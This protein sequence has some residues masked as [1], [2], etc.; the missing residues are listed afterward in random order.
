MDHF[1]SSNFLL[2]PSLCS[3]PLLPLTQLR[4]TRPPPPYHRAV[5]LPLAFF[6]LAAGSAPTITLYRYRFERCRAKPTRV[7]RLYQQPPYH[8]PSGFDVV[9]PGPPGLGSPPTLR[10]ASLPPSAGSPRPPTSSTFFFFF[11][12]P[13]RRRDQ[14][15]HT[16]PHLLIA[17][18]RR[19]HRRHHIA[20]PSPPRRPLSNFNSHSLSPPPPIDFPLLL[21]KVAA[22]ANQPGP[23]TI[24]RVLAEPG[25]EKLIWAKPVWREII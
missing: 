18:A 25:G 24:V 1:T 4:P 22:S 9:P 2:S 8:R 17:A 13:G 3:T 12:S 6:R 23:S 15:K 19:R 10:P 11:L 20:T 14:T 5:G 7:F 16:P 21:A